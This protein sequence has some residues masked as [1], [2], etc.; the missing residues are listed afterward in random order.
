LD[1]V[2]A[3]FGPA[4]IHAEEHVGP[5]AGFGAA[6]TGVDGEVGVAAV[7]GA[8]KHEVKLVAGECGEQVFV[9]LLNFL[10]AGGVAFFFGHLDED[11][12]V[13]GAGVETGEGFDAAFDAVDLVDD[14][15]GVALVVPEARGGHAFFELRK[16]AGLAWDVKDT[17]GV[18]R[19]GL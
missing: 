11:F 2:A 12:E 15:A 19:G 17:S 14:F 3:A 10:M 6:G 16:L 5:V 1:F 18:R 13:L 7:E 4:L 8:G 9:F